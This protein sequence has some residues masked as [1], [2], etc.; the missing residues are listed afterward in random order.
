MVVPYICFGSAGIPHTFK[1]ANIKRMYHILWN[2]VSINMPGR[3]SHK[4]AVMIF[5]GEKK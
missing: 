3:F 4:E 1:Y 5:D 2:I